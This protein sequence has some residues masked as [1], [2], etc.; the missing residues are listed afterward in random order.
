MMLA[1]ALLALVVTLSFTRAIA[2]ESCSSLDDCIARMQSLAKS[3]SSD[4]SLSGE[5]VELT[6][7]INEFE[8]SVARLVPL[9]ASADEKLASLAS[10][11]LRGASRIDAKYFPQIVAGLDRGLGW[12][13]PALCAMPG[14]AP[15]REAVARFLVSKDAP[16]NQEA[17]AVV[18]CGERALPF[19]VQ[20]AKCADGCSPRT[21]S[22]LAYVLHEM[23]PK[24]SSAIG[25]PL[26]E[27]ALDPHSAN[28]T[29]R[30][31]LSMIGELGKPASFLQADLLDLRSKRADLA[32]SIDAALIGLRANNAGRILAHRLSEAGSAFAAMLA[33]RDIAE[34][35]ADGRE[36]GE[37]VL[38]ILRGYD[39]QS[40]V[41]AARALGFIG[42]QPAV[43]LLIQAIDDPTDVRLNWAAVQSLGRLRSTA[44]T[45]ALL[46][47][48][49]Q[50][51]Y[52]PVRRAATEALAHIRDDTPYKSQFHPD[53]FAFEFFAY[54]QIADSRDE[55]AAIAIPPLPEMKA[56]T[57][58]ATSNGVSKLSYK[59]Q[60]EPEEPSGKA[61]AATRTPEIALRVANGWLTGTDHGEWGGEL[62]FIGDDRTQQVLVEQNVQDI[63]RLQQ[64]I[65]ALTGLAHL[66]MND[67]MIYELREVAGSWVAKPWRALPG[68]PRQS[69]L[70]DTGELAIDVY[71]GGSILVAPDGSM[72]M[73]CD[74]KIRS[75]P[76]Q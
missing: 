59:K 9:L 71:S 53:N 43:P 24:I 58:R 55:C 60:L 29:I 41:A 8:G 50:H 46:H 33:L 69:R 73:A 5:E 27:I 44:A 67:G 49:N 7:R 17:F 21:H 32:G 4:G 18:R 39:W 38:K 42:Y 19:M 22:N 47:A 26:L 62:M 36:A 68:A 61:R 10:V 30:G 23:D 12:L 74:A 48:A 11:S 45:D 1:R 3:S 51:W 20:A 76:K 2:T 25:R 28:D 65:V 15:A 52:S 34:L 54:E 35:G 37:E 16:E 63:F 40:R 6:D 70:V 31:V 13:P 57:L 56:R 14:E 66:T 64:R 72:R 75:K